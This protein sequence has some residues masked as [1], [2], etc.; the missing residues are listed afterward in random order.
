M[1][2][3]Q[4]ASNQLEFFIAA[5]AVG[6]LISVQVLFQRSSDVSQGVSACVIDNRK[7]FDRDKH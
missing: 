2:V 6:A 1:L 3:E 7:T 5:G 4:I